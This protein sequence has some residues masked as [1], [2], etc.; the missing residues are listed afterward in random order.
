MKARAKD[1]LEGLGTTIAVLLAIAVWF[2][3]A[4][5]VETELGKLWGPCDPDAVNQCQ[6]V[7]GPGPGNGR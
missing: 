7:T 3:A 2:A 5:L 6:T 4:Y 1:F